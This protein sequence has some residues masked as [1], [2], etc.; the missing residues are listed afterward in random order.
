MA[1][2]ITNVRKKG[3]D[4]VLIE[5]VQPPLSGDEGPGP[6]GLPAGDPRLREGARRRVLGLQPDHLRF[7]REDFEDAVHLGT[8][9]QRMRFEKYF[10]EQ[11]APKLRNQKAAAGSSPGRPAEADS[12][13]AVPNPGE[14]PDGDDG[15]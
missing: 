13:E 15:Q 8:P 12:D 1:R 3:A 11:V 7:A 10:C 14:D 5:A 4:V 6:R 9:A 2:I